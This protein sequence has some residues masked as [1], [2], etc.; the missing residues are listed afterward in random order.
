MYAICA[1]NPKLELFYKFIDIGDHAI[2]SNISG[3]DFVLI[4]DHNIK[5]NIKN[6]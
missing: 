1:K 6:N 3:A 2:I 4:F 5:P